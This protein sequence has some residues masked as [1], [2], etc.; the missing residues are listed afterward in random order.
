MN[1]RRSSTCQLLAAAVLALAAGVA[2]AVPVVYEGTIATP[3]TVTGS[4]GGNGWESETA[5]EVDFWRFSANAGD[6]LTAIGTRLAPGLDP[7]F[8]LYFGT[9]AADASLFLHDAD[10]GGLVFLTVADDETVVPGGPGGD[11]SLTGFLLPFTGNYT[12]A[13]GGIA[14]DGAGPFAYRLQVTAIPEP[15][16]TLLLGVGLGAVAWTRRV[17]PRRATHGG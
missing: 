6:R 15:E 9:T 8:T 2:D 11:P 17:R 1:S 16:I 13:F 10:W 3:G 5:A 12:I 4:V 7:V 14:S